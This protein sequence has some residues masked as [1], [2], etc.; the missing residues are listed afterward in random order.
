MLG[1]DHRHHGM[2]FHL[3]ARPFDEFF[4]GN[5]MGN[6]DFVIHSSGHYSYPAQQ[7][8]LQI[9]QSHILPGTFPTQPQTTIP[10]RPTILSR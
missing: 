2:N 7:H 6:P 10:H 9:Y 1:F 3:N 4:I 5:P 8:Q